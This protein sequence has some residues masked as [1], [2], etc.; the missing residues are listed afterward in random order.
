MGGLLFTTIYAVLCGLV[1]STVRWLLIDTLHA[2]L[3]RKPRQLNFSE[4]QERVAGYESIVA[5]TYRYYQHYSNMLVAAPIAWFL[6]LPS[7]R[8]R[9]ITLVL[10]I[11]FEWMYWRASVD[12]I[13]RYHHRTSMLLGES[14]TQDRPDPEDRRQ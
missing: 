13:Q 4:L 8:L 5:N 6:F 12:T 1:V 2:T 7:N 14:A 3:G 11:A 9:A 10:L